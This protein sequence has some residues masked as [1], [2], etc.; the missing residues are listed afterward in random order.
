MKKQR[1]GKSPA[2]G[3]RKG[4]GELSHRKAGFTGK[5][6]KNWKDKGK[7]PPQQKIFKRRGVTASN[8]RGRKAAPQA[9]EKRSK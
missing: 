1:K 7:G 2:A 4:G 9:G 8:K 6:T 3:L 5:V